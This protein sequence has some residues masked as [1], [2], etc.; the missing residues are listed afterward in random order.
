MIK[1]I[2]FKNYK[3]FPNWEEIEFRPV[4]LIIGKNSS[5]KSSVLKLIRM[6]GAM[7]RG[8]INNPEVEFNG[9]TLGGSYSDLFHNRENS[10][11]ALSVEFENGINV[12]SEY[13]V[14][15]DD[16]KNYNHTM[17]HP[18]YGLY[19]LD[20]NNAKFVDENITKRWKVDCSSLL[21]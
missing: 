11:L 7:I 5:G 19:R 14:D 12:N 18:E 20:D 16:I 17:S 10:G 6:I 8:T 4:T 9:I 3:A 21:K 15:N 1:Y 13:F 2:R